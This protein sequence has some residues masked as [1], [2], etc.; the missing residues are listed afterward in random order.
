MSNFSDCTD[1]EDS[2]HSHLLPE[3]RTTIS[4][5]QLLAPEK[6][7]SDRQWDPPWNNVQRKLAHTDFRASCA[8]DQNR[9]PPTAPRGR[10]RGVRSGRGLSRHTSKSR[11]DETENENEWITPTKHRKNS[12]RRRNKQEKLRQLANTHD[13]FER[14][15]FNSYP[16]FYSMKFPSIEIWTKINQIA[17]DKDSKKQISEPKKIKKLNKDTLLIELKSDNQ[18]KKLKEVKKIADL[19]VVIRETNHSTKAREW[20]IAGQCLTL[21]LRNY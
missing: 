13:Q 14:T 20:S 10:G 9:Y 4:P 18:G 2:R 8:T 6:R 1:D 15:R 21:P 16:K 19:K 7:K 3:Q 17:V 11:A 12:N 5:G